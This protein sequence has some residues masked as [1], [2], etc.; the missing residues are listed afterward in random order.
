MSGG[1]EVALDRL[2]RLRPVWDRRGRRR[3]GEE[4]RAEDVG[5][6]VAVG[7]DML[8]VVWVRV[9][10]ESPLD[11]GCWCANLGIE[12]NA[13]VEQVWI[14]L[15]RCRLRI[16]LGGHV[17]HYGVEAR[18]DKLGVVL[19]EHLAVDDGHVLGLLLEARLHKEKLPRQY[20]LEEH[21]IKHGHA[22]PRV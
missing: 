5:V 1:S 8:H 3:G 2:V 21:A 14:R 7:V 9:R 19:V 4:A 22:R 6:R 15:T 10:L 17:A 20:H 11:E 12:R 13:L 18:V 16:D